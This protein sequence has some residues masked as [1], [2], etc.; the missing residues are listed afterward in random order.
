LF[1]AGALLAGELGAAFVFDLLVIV[2]VIGG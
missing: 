1:R 2:L